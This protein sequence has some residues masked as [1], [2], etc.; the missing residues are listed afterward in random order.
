MLQ[1]WQLLTVNNSCKNYSASNFI[2]FER[3]GPPI[4]GYIKIIYLHVANV[5]SSGHLEPQLIIWC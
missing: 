2:E 3:M 4:P 5:M 1:Q